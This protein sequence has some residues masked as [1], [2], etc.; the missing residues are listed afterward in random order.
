MSGQIRSR[1]RGIFECDGKMH[2]RCAQTCLPGQVAMVLASC[3]TCLG[4]DLFFEKDYLLGRRLNWYGLRLTCDQRCICLS[5][6]HVCI[7]DSHCKVLGIPLTQ[8]LS[9]WT[10]PCSQGLCSSML[11][12]VSAPVVCVHGH[13]KPP[14]KE[15]SSM[16]GGWHRAV[17][18]LMV[19]SLQSSVCIV[20]WCDLPSFFGLAASLF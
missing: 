18:P 10:S 13:G 1:Y 14:V 9:L 7:F 3:Q 2:A 15:A 11:L 16:E 6:W 4:E 19:F 20:V 8:M 5:F 12:V 17:C